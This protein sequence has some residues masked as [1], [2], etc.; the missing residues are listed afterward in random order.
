MDE[1][2][3][4][5]LRGVDGKVLTVVEI[6]EF[7]EKSEQNKR[8]DRVNALVAKGKDIIHGNAFIAKGRDPTEFDSKPLEPPIRGQ[9]RR[10]L[11]RTMSSWGREHKLPKPLP[12]G[13][14]RQFF[15][16]WVRV[17]RRER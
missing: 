10:A 13:V 15:R 3:R 1:I 4:S 9:G 16:T 11:T 14:K 12:T 6:E 8:N 5:E 2:G 7:F 17:V